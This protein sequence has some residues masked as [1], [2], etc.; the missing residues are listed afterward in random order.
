MSGFSATDAAFTGIRFV[1][2]RP[3]AVAIWA[4]AQIII[5]IVFGGITVALMGSYMVQMQA[6]R[7][8]HPPDPAQVNMAHPTAVVMASP[9][10]IQPKSEV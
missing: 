1:R 4:G 7:S 5:S 3:V 9:P 2:E 8:Q 6:L 10:G